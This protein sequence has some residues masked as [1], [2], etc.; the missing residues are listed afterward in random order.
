VA[1]RKK[2]RKN[3]KFDKNE[4]REEVISERGTNRKVF[5]MKNGAHVMAISGESMHYLDKESGKYEEIKNELTPSE[6]GLGCKCGEY[7]ITLPDGKNNAET[8]KLTK[9]TSSIE[10]TY[11]GKDIHSKEKH[12]RGKKLPV[13]SVGSI[14]CHKPHMANGSKRKQFVQYGNVDDSIDIEYE[15]RNNALKENIVIRDRSDRYNFEFAVKVTDLVPE[16]DS[17]KKTI[18]FTDPEKKETKFSIPAPVM[19][20][21]KKNYSSAVEYDLKAAGKDEYILTVK[22]DSEWINSSDR[23]M[24]VYLD[25]AVQFDQNVDVPVGYVNSREG[26]DGISAGYDG[27]INWTSTIYALLNFNSENM[28]YTGAYLYLE[29]HSSFGDTDFSWS[30]S[31][32]DTEN[33]ASTKYYGCIGDDR[34]YYMIPVSDNV[35]AAIE[36]GKDVTTFR[37]E[38][39]IT[40]D[41]VGQVVFDP[42]T[43]VLYICYRDTLD[44]T[45]NPTGMYIR[46]DYG[47]ATENVNLFTGELIH[48]HVDVETGSAAFPISIA[49]KFT[50]HDLTADIGY[51]LGWTLAY[52]QY[53]RYEYV[54]E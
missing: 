4:I 18:K 46:A 17:D 53:I 15:V 10:W 50:G 43:A 7:E 22:A 8:V 13:P 35:A 44:Y 31:G 52:D 34:P 33:E 37:L 21:A 5:K 47:S 48:T 14:P 51:G 32:L 26:F 41:S 6:Q 16:I 29:E 11:I 40:A 1:E 36:D 30:L 2:M 38:P 54:D 42:S 12:G 27:L 28:V 23:T 39:T 19:Y 9:D 3:F 45:D 24:P 25:P 49:H 20:D